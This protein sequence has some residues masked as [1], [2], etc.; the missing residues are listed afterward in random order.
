MSA[1]MVAGAGVLVASL[2]GSEWPAPSYLIALFLAAIVASALFIPDSLGDVQTFGP[3]VAA[4]GLSLVGAS[5]TAVAMAVGTV[6]GH[7]ALRRRPLV[8]ALF[9][10]GAWVLATR[11]AGGAAYLVFVDHPS[12]ARPIFRGQVDE[13]FVVAALAAAAT[14]VAVSVLLVGGGLSFHRRTPF[15]GGLGWAVVSHALVTTVLFGVGTIVGLVAARALPISSLFW[16]IP[17]LGAAVAAL[18]HANHL[19]SAAELEV[20]HTTAGDLGRSL[21]LDDVVQTLA[22]GVD[23]TL[24]ADIFSI[25]M[26]APGEPE[27]RVVHYRGPGGMALARQLEPDALSAH[28][29]RAGKAIRLRN[30]EHDARRSARA[31]VV[32]GPGVIRS[33]LVVPIVGG[34]QAWGAIALFKG[35][36]SYFTA[37]HERF[38]TSLADQT[39]MAIRGIH[40]LEHDR[41]QSDRLTSLQQ[42]GF[43]PG[44]TLN[45]DDACRHLVTRAAE[46]LGTKYAFLALIDPQSRELHGQV[47]HGADG[48]DFAR[49]RAR[50]EGEFAALHEMARAIRDRRPVICGEAEVRD[51][52]CPSLRALSDVRSALA[53]PLIRQGR[54]V[55]ALLVARIEPASFT[56]IEITALQS[57]A[58]YGTIAIEN[59]RQH[60]AVEEHLRRSEAMV[61]VLKRL[62]GASD[63]RGVF[64]LV[65]EGFRDVFGVGRCL[66]LVWDGHGSAETFAEGLSEEFVNAT[67]HH[68]H[69]VIGRHVTQAAHP[70][71]VADLAGDARMAPLANAAS[72]AGIRSGIFF[73]MRS[74]GAF[75]GTLALLDPGWR[76]ST[77]DTL[78]LAEALVEQVTM[79]VKN[80]GLLAR[81]ERRRDELVVLNR[82]VGAVT[83][84]LDLSEIFRTAAAEL[85]SALDV[86][87]VSVYRVEGPWLRLAAQIGAADAPGEL[88]TTAGVTG[89]VVRNRRPEFVP[90]V[91]DEP[92]Y[93]MSSFDVTSLAVVPIVQDNGTTGVLR[94]EGSSAHPV[95]PQAFEFLTAFAQQLSIAVRNATFYEEQRRAHDELQVLYEAAKAVSGTLD[96]RTVLDS[97]VSVTCRAFDYETGTLFMVDPE[98]GDLT[99]ESAYGHK[100]SMVGTRLPSDAGIVGW[101]ARTGAPLV[102]DDVV[103]DS[104]YRQM[105]DR[106][107]SELAVPLIAEGKVL[108]VF[109]VESARLAAFGQRDMRLLTTLASYAVVA[110]Q[111]ARLYEQASRMAITDGLTELYNHRYLH[112]AL[113][114]ILERAR[115][116]GQPIGLIMLEIDHFKRYNDTYGHRSGDEALRVVAGLLRRGSR[117]S[118]ITARYGGDEFMVVL[119][120]A[121]KAATQETAE[122]LRRAVE[123]YPLILG[124]EIITSVTLSV[125]VAAYPQDGRTVDALVEAVDRAQYIAKRSGGNKVH[126]AHAP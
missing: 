68:I 104:R 26:R 44:A 118:D 77:P 33:A 101:V 89:R 110:I 42:V 66:L 84:S 12:W 85:A 102:V 80:A 41:R 20:L 119:P 120:G 60:A 91:R 59:A 96:L 71:V 54:S 7:A 72:R 47:A 13:G 38:V 31:D 117:P 74:Q 6:L 100:E 115:R 65:A 16:L 111:N 4:A 5:V 34:G 70:V 112:D 81:S 122:R 46:M 49:L 113:D 52:P 108:G 64:A 19:Q 114:R 79:A 82:L 69:A 78:L 73:P 126:V 55:G 17:S 35:T 11:A 92:D 75:L 39:A 29:I 24:A 56:E 9:Y 51:S 109:N 87:R 121:S 43:L 93:I 37:R 86:P 1:V 67:T 30:Y 15:A 90:N 53:V 63:L 116:D 21:S 83:A 14:F 50:P 123:A 25:Y 88:P 58:A 32:F 57:V 27:P 62:C 8:Q 40:L 125:G 94:V 28:A 2:V 105:D 99:V 3:A 48:A 61:G 23:R 98:T 18:V 95:T 97:L 107:R 36:R 103:N 106:T 124:D 22:S 76:E 10:A 45:P